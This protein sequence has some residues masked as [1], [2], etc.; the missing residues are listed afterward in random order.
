MS[1]ELIRAC[2]SFEYDVMLE[3]CVF[4]SDTWK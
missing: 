4:I 1:D 2:H 3:E